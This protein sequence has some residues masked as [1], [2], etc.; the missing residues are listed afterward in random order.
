[1]AGEDVYKR[2][3][4][5]LSF[6]LVGTGQHIDYDFLIQ[7]HSSASCSHGFH[8]HLKILY[9]KPVDVETHNASIT[10]L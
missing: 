7:I 2:Q 8:N 10:S 9:H 4:N 1:M 5:T 3:S 6:H